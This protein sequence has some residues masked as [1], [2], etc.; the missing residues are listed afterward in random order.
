[1][2]ITNK[3][4]KQTRDDD[5]SSSKKHHQTPS[6]IARTKEKNYELISKNFVKKCECVLRSGQDLMN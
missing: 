1:M 2:M 6:T 4:Q 3:K 5:D